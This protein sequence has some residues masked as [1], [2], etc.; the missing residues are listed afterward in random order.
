[1]VYSRRDALKIGA[2]AAGALALG[3]NPLWAMPARL[4]EG[5]LLNT[6]P[7]SGE[8][9]PAMGLGTDSS[10]SRVARVLDEHGRLREVLRLF[11]EL[12]GRVIDAAPTFD[13]AERVLGQLTDEIGNKEEIFW[14]A[15]LSIRASG[16]RDAGMIQVEQSMERLGAIDLEQIHDLLRWQIQLPLLQDLKQE[17]RIRYVGVTTSS[18]GQYDLLEPILRTESLDFVQL[19]YAVDNRGAERALIPIARDRGIAT[20]VNSPFSRGRLFQRVGDR[21]VPEW[22]HAFGAHTWAQFFLK[23]VLGH[24][25]VTAVVPG[26]S[27]PEHLRD[28]MRAGLGRLPNEE[29]RTRMARL[30]DDLPDSAG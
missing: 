23:W 25:S 1:M 11:T 30:I 3:R 8:Q 27:D 4:Q 24:D 18:D 5:Q 14:A 7:A 13:A 16:G 22:A 19:D 17:E 28:N 21:A 29:E 6:I 10:F 9:I 26:T 12:G 20:L 2:A 15:K